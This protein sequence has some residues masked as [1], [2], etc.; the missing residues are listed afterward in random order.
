LPLYELLT[1]LFFRLL[2]YVETPLVLEMF[3]RLDP[4]MVNCRGQWEGDGV[5]LAHVWGG[6]LKFGDDLET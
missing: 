2:M 1:L 3:V 5:V 4:K 6:S